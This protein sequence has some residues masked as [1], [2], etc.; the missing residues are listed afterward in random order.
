MSWVSL[1]SVYSVQPTQTIFQI[2]KTVIM[3]NLSTFTFADLWAMQCAMKVHQ[4][5]KMSNKEW[6][7][8]MAAIR[9]EVDK[10]LNALL[11]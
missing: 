8:A 1:I 5:S 7:E 3:K 4:P 11:Y 9:E 2:I 6:F 10:R